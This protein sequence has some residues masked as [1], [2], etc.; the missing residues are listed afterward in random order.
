[1][2]LCC[3]LALGWASAPT[4]A[5]SSQ[6]SRFLA[7][8]EQ[9][10]AQARGAF[11]DGTQ[12]IWNG[13]RNVPLQWYD[14]RLG[15][16]PRYPLATIWG[17]VP[18][19]EALSAAAIADPSAANR[20][21]LAAFAAGPRPPARAPG[22]APRSRITVY[23]GAES[24][25]DPA[26]GGYAP[27]PGDRGPANTWFDDN[28]WWGIAFMDAYRAL[29]TARFLADAQRALDF[30]ATRGWD[31]AG[32]GLWWNTAHI[33]RGQKSGEALAAAS[34][35]GALLAQA[36][37]RAGNPSA[38]A[39]D[40][41][42]VQRFLA[43]GDAHFADGNGLYWRTQGDPTPMPY[44]AGP[45]VEA[46]EL[47]C[48]LG[49]PG[50][51]WCARARRLADAAAQRFADRL[52]MGPQYDAIYLHWMLV[53]AGQAGDRR[54]APLALEMAG[55]A[56]ANARVAS[57]LYLRAWDGSDMSRHQ[58]APGMLRTDAATVELFAWLAADGP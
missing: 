31:A 25:W 48:G 4:R 45:E 2:L 22:T 55:D 32:G 17:A 29:G 58:A 44:V 56:Q 9:G 21:A 20:A 11:R 16:R 5:L 41:Q 43:W 38:A 23:G 10:L 49:T 51:A 14:E 15:A 57:G 33:P 3:A 18:L 42:V 40:V 54:W 36:W 53:Y 24:Y 13:R 39:A 26:V 47:L 28:A 46:N 37:T 12:G 1:M 50:N 30:V 34:L 7:L 8:A 35:L 6:Q 19:F 52:N 27:Y